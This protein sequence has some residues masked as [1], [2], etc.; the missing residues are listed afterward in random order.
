MGL[1]CIGIPSISAAYASVK[2]Q[3]LPMATTTLNLV[4]RMGGPALTTLCAT[5]LGWR[6]AAQTTAPVSSAFSAAFA[7]LC[8]FHLVLIVAATRL[9]RRV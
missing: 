7:L 2:R 1:S 8:G 6:L 5:F 3:D 9:P 4:M